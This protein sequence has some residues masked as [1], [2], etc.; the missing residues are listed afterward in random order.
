[1]VRANH[2]ERTSR[3]II[4]KSEL[5][6]ARKRYGEALEIISECRWTTAMVIA[7]CTKNNMKRI[8]TWMMKV[9]KEDETDR[10]IVE[11]VSSA[12]KTL[13]KNPDT[14]YRFKRRNKEWVLERIGKEPNRFMVWEYTE[15]VCSGEGWPHASKTET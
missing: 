14:F 15:I 6:G 10:R 5:E 3:G 2:G 9:M 4:A 1:M 12:L 7:N 11:M 13:N 8:S